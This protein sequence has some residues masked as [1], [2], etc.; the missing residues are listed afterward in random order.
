MSTT[1][2]LVEALLRKPR[3]ALRDELVKRALA[4]TYHDWKSTLSLPKSQLVADLERA[5]YR[6]L[7]ARTRAGEFDEEPDEADNAAFAK[8]LASN[9][10]HAALWEELRGCKTVEEAVAAVSKHVSPGEVLAALAELN[11]VPPKP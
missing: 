3:S 2:T 7:A 6:E 10:A 11:W 8:D 4:G 1:T 9:P 5:G